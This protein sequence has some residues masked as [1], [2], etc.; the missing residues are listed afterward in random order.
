MLCGHAPFYGQSASTDRIIERIKS[1]QF[2]FEGAEWKGV[3][4]AAKDVIMGMLLGESPIIPM[5]S[6]DSHYS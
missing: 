4:A 6:V 2:S 5:T 3:S 1:G